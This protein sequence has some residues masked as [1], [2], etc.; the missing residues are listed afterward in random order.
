MLERV[1][2]LEVPVLLDFNCSARS[3]NDVLHQV[4][5][6]GEVAT[7]GAVEQPY[8]VGN[9]VDHA[10]LASRLDVPLSLDEGVRTLRDLSQIVRHEAASVVCVK[11]ARVGGLANARTLIAKANELGLRVYLGGFFESPFARRVHRTLADNCISEPSDLD[12][13]AL[14]ENVVEV[15]ATSTSFG[16]EPAAA[17]LAEAE[18]F[19]V[20]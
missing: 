20:L 1:A 14:R 2:A 19:S 17:V 4:D 6:I 8:D 13:V 16:V 18:A 3:D 11:P 12:D 9:I 5:Q 7:I 15:E 10:R